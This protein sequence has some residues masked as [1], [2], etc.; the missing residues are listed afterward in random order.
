MPDKMSSHK[1]HS[2]HYVCT[3]RDTVYANSKISRNGIAHNQTA[4]L[5]T[6]M[7]FSTYSLKRNLLQQLLLLTEPMGVAR[8]LSQTRREI[9]G[10]R[11]RAG[12]RFLESGQQHS[13]L[14]C[15]KGF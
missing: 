14:Y 13:V 15:I 4:H 12:K 5:S 11:P 9:R 2:S 3:T 1:L 10:R 8:S 7:F 6:A